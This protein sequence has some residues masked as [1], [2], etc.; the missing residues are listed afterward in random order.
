MK[1]RFL[2]LALALA[3][4]ALLDGCISGCDCS[5]PYVDVAPTFSFEEMSKMPSF[6]ATVE[7]GDVHRSIFSSRIS[8]KLELITDSNP[9]LV[10]ESYQASKTIVGFVQ[11]LE[12]GHRYVFPQV[13]LDYVNRQGSEVSAVE[14]AKR[15]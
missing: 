9:D 13:Y 7:S 12:G 11:S 14:G 5:L 4:M 10:L 2:M 8:V 1:I 15:D 6:S 3:G